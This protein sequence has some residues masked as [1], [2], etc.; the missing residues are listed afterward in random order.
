MLSKLK[1]LV[2]KP[3]LQAW[4][5]SLAQLAAAWY[6]YPSKRMIV[7]G[8]TGTN[9]KTTTANLVARLLEEAGYAVGLTTT[10]NFR[11]AGKEEVNAMKMTMPGRF[12]L[13][14][15]LHRM[16]KAGCR[17]A[18]IETSSQ[19]IEQYRHLGVEYDIAVFT[20]LTPEHIEA[21]GGF[22]AYKNAK[23]KLFRS[24]ARR[25]RKSVPWHGDVRKVSVV[26]LESEH[27]ADFLEPPADKKYGFL[28]D[29]GAK[30][31]GKARWPIAVVKA[32]N[33]EI[34]TEGSSFEVRGTKFD[35]LLPGRYNLMNALAAVCVGLSQALPLETMA[36]A[37]SKVTGVPGRFEFIDEG[38]EF[39]VIVD[40]A[41]E[42][43][44]L[45]QLYE[46]VKA[47]PGKRVIHVL[48]SAGGGRDAAR[49]PVLGGIAGRNADIVIVT[50][51]DP[52]D[53]D[54]QA[55]IEAVAGG[56]EAAGKKEGETLF[57]LPDRRQ[58][59]K[60]AVEI[61]R[62]GHVVLLTGKGAEQAIAG[63]GGELTPWDERETAR[64][65]LRHRL[66]KV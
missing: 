14:R 35:L 23:L 54:P 63:K 37:L 34:R 4:H 64:E 62:D 27:A 43:E 38:Q 20:N 46:V 21:H 47:M 53:E 29:G 45:R 58:A 55:I 15:M 50:N 7:I 32:T 36:R 39:S 1:K 6:G 42:P 18:V 17:Y 24:L 2:P 13:Q 48:G 8:V 25:R 52:Y 16:D 66:G 65:L 31:A 49:R 60:K 41:P 9:G 22:E 40:Y 12:F 59:I 57:R 19:G 33:A 56:A 26:N 28:A 10:V 30:S 51:E 61:A 44:S 5:W 3:L 11:I